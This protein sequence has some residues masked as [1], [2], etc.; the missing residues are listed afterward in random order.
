MEQLP[1]YQGC[2]TLDGVTFRR[3]MFG[4]VSM[5]AELHRACLS[6]RT[7]HP[8]LLNRSQIGTTAHPGHSHQDCSK[9]GTVPAT[10]LPS[11]SQVSCLSISIT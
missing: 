8:P 4:V 1:Q 2:P 7:D 11:A 3:A 10:G 9:L 5:L 6:L